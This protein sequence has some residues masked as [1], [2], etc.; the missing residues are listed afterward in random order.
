[1]VG[2]N[3]YQFKF[4]KDFRKSKSNSFIMESDYMNLIHSNGRI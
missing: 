3:R 2:P 1:M 4:S